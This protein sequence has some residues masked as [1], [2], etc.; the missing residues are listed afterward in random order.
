MNSFNSLTDNVIDLNLTLKMA[1]EDIHYY[2]KIYKHKTDEVIGYCGIRLGQNE[3]FKY[4]GNI[5]YEIVK[6]HRGNNYS[7]RAGILLTEIAKFHGFDNILITA[8]PNNIASIKVIEKL[9]CSYVNVV[10]VPKESR[11]YKTGHKIVTVYNMDL[12]ESG[13]KK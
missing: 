6:E 5:E 2:Y 8:N 13:R 11:L 1:K 12:K 4:L 7:V 3:E 10:A 9:G